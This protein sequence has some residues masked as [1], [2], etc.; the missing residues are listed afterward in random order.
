M[1]YINWM[2]SSQSEKNGIEITVTM[3]FNIDE[4]LLETESP[5]ELASMIEDATE[6]S[7][8]RLRK[9]LKKRENVVRVDDEGQITPFC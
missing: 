5:Q 8:K 2:S 4:N 1:S 7:L 9:K 3:A 6:R